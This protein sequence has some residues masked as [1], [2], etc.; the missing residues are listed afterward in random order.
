[1]TITNS[2]PQVDGGTRYLIKGRIHSVTV[3]ED[4]SGRLTGFVRNLLTTDKRYARVLR[5]GFA[6]VRDAAT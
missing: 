1:M 3:D 5:A 4:D 2:W 6:A